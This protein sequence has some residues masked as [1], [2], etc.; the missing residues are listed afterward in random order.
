[1]ESNYVNKERLFR[2]NATEISRRKSPFILHIERAQ[3]LLK[4]NTISVSRDFVSGFMRWK[5]SFASII[6]QRLPQRLRQIFTGG[7]ITYF[8]PRYLLH[9]CGLMILASTLPFMATILEKKTSYSESTLNGDRESGFQNNMVHFAGYILDLPQQSPEYR[10]KH[11]VKDLIIESPKSLVDLTIKDISY[12]F[13][14][15]QLSKK[16]GNSYMW[17]FASDKCV[18]D[19]YFKKKRSQKLPQA[20]IEHF[21]MRSRNGDSLASILSLSEEDVPL[22]S[23]Q[24]ACVKSILRASEFK[25][26]TVSVA[27]YLENGA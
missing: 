2:E 15:L 4:L 25:G 14:H 6:N 24:S 7:V 12:V 19:V 16:S 27:D 13:D 9:F 26:Q 1:M 17:Q 22:Q 23:A 21:D 18:L 3:N 5:K 20:Q 8:K 11:A 10:Y